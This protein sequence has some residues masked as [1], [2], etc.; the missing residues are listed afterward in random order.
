MNIM[1]GQ[2]L[3]GISGSLPPLP[4]S[5]LLSYVQFLFLH[6]LGGVEDAISSSMSSRLPLI[7]AAVSHVLFVLLMLSIFLLRSSPLTSSSL[8]S[9]AL[10]TG[11]RTHDTSSDY[12]KFIPWFSPA[13]VLVGEGFPDCHVHTLWH[14]KRS[15]RGQTA[16]LSHIILSYS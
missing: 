7:S 4:H 9:M 11:S 3:Q 15:R 13:I 5:W 8:P 14:L 1:L 2:L 16:I 12:G 6:S 10:A